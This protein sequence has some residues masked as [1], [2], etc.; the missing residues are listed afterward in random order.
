LLLVVGGVAGRLAN[1]LPTGKA[2]RGVAVNEQ[3]EQD[4]WRVLGV[5]GATLV[6]PHAAQVE[7]ADGIHDEVDKM[8]R[9]HLL[10]QVRREQEWRV[11]V[12]MNEAGGRTL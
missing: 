5:A 9:R 2:P 10:P 6:A 8:I 3:P 1:D 7:F 4:G 11:V 12:D